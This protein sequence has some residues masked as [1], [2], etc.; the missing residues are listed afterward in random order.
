MTTPSDLSMPRD[1]PGIATAE[2]GFVLLDGPNGIAM[3]MTPHAADVTGR[4]LIEAAQTA[5]S[6]RGNDPDLEGKA[7]AEPPGGID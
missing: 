5:W 2:Q 4:N 7:A 3:T 1:D 6:Q